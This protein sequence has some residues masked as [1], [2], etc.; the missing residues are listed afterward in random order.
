M[1]PLL[2]VLLGICPEVELLD[3]MVIL[4]L[5][6]L[7]KRHTV[8]HRGRPISHSHHWG[9]RFNFS[10]SS[11]TLV[12]FCEVLTHVL[13]IFISLMITRGIRILI[14]RLSPALDSLSSHFQSSP[15]VPDLG[16]QTWR[17]SWSSVCGVGGGGGERLSDKEEFF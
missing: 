10:T 11:P 15:W 1:S 2:S 5:I 12:I 4:F 8:F 3:H 6:F 17:S 16:D 9:T 14:N 13:F 7:K